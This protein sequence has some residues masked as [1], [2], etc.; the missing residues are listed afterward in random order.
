MSNLLFAGIEYDFS[1]NPIE[2]LKDSLSQNT[3]GADPVSLLYDV[4]WDPIIQ[5]TN[6][7]PTKPDDAFMDPIFQA[8][9]QNDKNSLTQILKKRKRNPLHLSSNHEKWTALHLAASKP[10]NKECLELLLH[11][12]SYN[13]LVSINDQ[14]NQGETALHIACKYGCDENARLLLRSGCNPKMKTRIGDSALHI[15]ASKGYLK[16]VQYLLEYGANIRSIDNKDNLPLHLACHSGNFETACR[17]LE[18][19]SSTINEKNSDGITPFMFAISNFDTHGL[20]F[21]LENGA[22][23]DIR[24]EFGRMAFHFATS[25]IHI[26]VFSFLIQSMNIN[27]IEQY[28]LSNAF[29]KKGDFAFESDFTFESLTCVTIQMGPDYL[30]VLLN[31]DLP[32]NILQMPSF[33]VGIFDSIIV[34][35]PLAYLFFQFV[36]KKIMHFDRCLD[37]LLK[38]NMTI[39][40]EFKRISLPQKRRAYSFFQLFDPLSIIL[41][42]TKWPD[43]REHYLK[44]LIANGVTTDYNL[45]CY[46]NNNV[47]F[48]TFNEYK[49]YY[50]PVMCAIKKS[51]IET[52]EFLVSNSVILE[53]D[54]LC[55]YLIKEFLETFRSMIGDQYKAQ[56]RASAHAIYKYLINLK[57]VYYKWSQ[58]QILNRRLM[59]V[60]AAE[61]LHIDYLPLQID[62][63]YPSFSS[64][65]RYNCDR[66]FPYVTAAE[67]FCNVKL[68]QLCRTTIR[69]QLR[70][71]TLEGNLLNFRKKIFKLPLPNKLKDYLLFK[72]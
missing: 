12:D 45:Q 52:V 50:D 30:N 31:S 15:A 18:H 66:P 3:D 26:D 38:Y 20:R 22:R 28:Y 17:L 67:E 43:N 14:T 34:L 62:P 32:Q 27:Y 33:Q 46:H 39:M 55:N 5:D 19:D 57:P 59:F 2:V 64:P 44:L 8:V 68:I 10:E 36:E 37:L 72:E 29:N 53:P 49:Y 47:L 61:H 41:D 65:G 21:L 71:P 1:R 51:D 24:D 7:P 42:T 54:K 35:S 9:Q 25:S 70:E 60:P 23:T 48:S 69:Q 4:S 16:I 40:D 63:I 56:S 6:E 58:R 11:Y 13:I